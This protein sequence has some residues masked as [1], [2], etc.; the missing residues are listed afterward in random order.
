MH[1]RRLTAADADSYQVLRLQALRD[2]PRA[3]SSSYEEECATPLANVAAF[4]AP[5]SGRQVLGAFVDGRLAGMVGLGRDLRRKAS[6]KAFIR[7]MYVDPEYRGRKIARR[8]LEEAV[9]VAHSLGGVRQVTLAVTAGNATAVALYQ[10]LGFVAF[11]V[12]PRALQLNGVF[13][14]DVHMVLLIDARE[15]DPLS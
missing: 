6:H 11:G 15:I 9:A 12:E 14:D 10:S 4:L 8:L 2:S 5:E 7:S 3:F 1:I 13:I